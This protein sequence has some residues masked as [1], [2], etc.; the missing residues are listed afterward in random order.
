MSTG[1]IVLHVRAGRRRDDLDLFFLARVADLQLE[2]EPVELRFRQRIRAFLLDRILRGEHE[3]RLGQL[4]RLA[5]AVTR[6]SCIASSSAACVFGGARLISSARTMLAKIGPG[7]KRNSRLPVAGSSSSSSVP[8][9]S[10]RHE[11]RR[12]LHAREGRGRAPARA[13]G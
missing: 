3:E 1:L 9:M 10:R 13:S 2:H 12:E 4:V 5:A 6:C 7:A 11:I 8:V